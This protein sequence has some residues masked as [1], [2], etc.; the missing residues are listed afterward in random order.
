MKRILMINWL[1]MLGLICAYAQWTRMTNLPT[2]YIDTYGG[3]SITSKTTY[4]YATMR[5][6]DEVD[7]LTVYDSLEIRGRGNSTWNLQKKP[8]KLKFHEKE[9]LLGKGYAKAK[10]WT[11]LANAA[12]KTLIRNA[13]TSALGEFTTLKFNPGYKFVDL[14]LNGAFLGCYQLSDH[15]DVRPHRVDVVEQ[16]LP[17]TDDSDITGGYLLEVDGFKD[18]NCFTTSSYSVPIRIHYPDEDDIVASQNTYIR[19][20]IAQFERSLRSSDFKDPVLGYRAF[21][22]STSLIDWF[23]C[24]EISA[25]LDG[26]YSTYFYKDQGDSLLYWGPIW[27]ADIA[28]G[29]DYRV[30]AT[31]DKLMTDVGFGATKQW[32]NRMWQDDWFA[33]KVYTRYMELLEHGLVDHLFTQIDSL[34][35]LLA[36]SQELNY[37]RWGIDR[38]MYHEIV[39]YSSYDEYISYLRSFISAHCAFLEEA[40]ADRKP[41]DPTPPFVASN[42]FYRITNAGSAKAIE[43]SSTADPS[44]GV[45]QQWENLEDA[46]SE[47]WWV[48]KANGHYMLLNRASLRALNDP[49]QGEVGPTTN[50]GTALDTA[51]EDSLDERQ[52]WDIIPQ[53]TAGY[54]NLLNV[55]T[56]HIANLSSG[57]SANGT[58]ILSYTNDERNASSRN[59][60][61]Y[62]IPTKDAIPE[63]LTGIRD[64][65]PEEYALAYNPS[66]DELHFGSETP[67]LLSRLTVKVYDASGRLVGNF[68]GDE[69]FSMSGQAH[70]VYIVTWRCGSQQR[71]VKFLKP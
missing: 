66:T 3:R 21:V 37:Q 49:T 11:L 71:S 33:R 65:E 19:N 27:D 28:Y 23:L 52:L 41:V 30:T 51:P 50:V 24:T 40:F 18:G 31:V 26:Y 59:R 17:L 5:Y 42:Y 47:D 54:Y 1:L 16:D 53:G 22:D 4:I 68:R 15:V 8:Y 39:L 6:V 12:D 56:Q 69:R 2:I 60:L 36:E 7:Q 14:V 9:K 57:N 67:E 64:I 46:E 32:L 45:V 25:N 10:K 55:Y 13:V 63:T 35:E 20:Y 61:W 43:E 34:Q 58:P 62:F 48:K 70:G 38:R 44:R 29:N